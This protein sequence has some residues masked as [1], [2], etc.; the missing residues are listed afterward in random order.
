MYLLAQPMFCGAWFAEGCRNLPI[1]STTIVPKS[2]TIVL[3]IFQ[4]H[5]KLFAWAEQVRQ[6]HPRP[7]FFTDEE[8]NAV[9]HQA[10]DERVHGVEPDR[11]AQD[12]RG[13]PRDAQ[14]RDLQSPWQTLATA[15]SSRDSFQKIVKCL[16]TILAVS[17]A[18]IKAQQITNF[19][20]GGT[21]AVHRRGRAFEVAP[22][23][24]VPWLQVPAEEACQGSLAK[25]CI[26]WPL[27]RVQ[28]SFF[29]SSGHVLTNF[30]PI[31]EA[32]WW[33]EA[34]QRWVWHGE[35]EQGGG[36]GA[37]QGGQQALRRLPAAGG[38]GEELLPGA[39]SCLL[40]PTVLLL[41][42]QFLQPQPGP[43]P[44][45]GHRAGPGGAAHDR[46]LAPDGGEHR[47]GLLPHPWLGLLL[48]L[49]GPAAPARQPEPPP[50]LTL[51]HTRWPR[52]HLRGRLRVLLFLLSF[53]PLVTWWR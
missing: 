2:P 17:L 45:G 30:D 29:K 9:P 50:A 48:V 44:Q 39:A 8:A 33:V 25:A 26:M 19:C 16:F 20:S 41:P 15:L 47:P 40:P 24:R 1:M 46:V 32:R 6:I 22:H 21:R 52:R 4:T 42:L 34:L 38:G 49:D 51:P 31:G 11:E 37:R 27:M 12:H 35:R 10:A 13:D 36:G 14:R 28:L 18:L 53:C 7:S 23:D 5:R 43:H 3:Q